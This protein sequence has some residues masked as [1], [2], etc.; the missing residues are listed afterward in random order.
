MHKTQQESYLWLHYFLILMQTLKNIFAPSS[1]LGHTW[2]R[3]FHK[4]PNLHKPNKNTHCLLKYETKLID[5]E[6]NDKIDLWHMDLN[7]ALILCVVS[8]CCISFTI[9]FWALSGHFT[10]V[11][12]N[13]EATTKKCHGSANATYNIFFCWI[14]YPKFSLYQQKQPIPDPSPE[15]AP[16]PQG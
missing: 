2:C 8:S 4:T 10:E 14:N 7:T 12:R 6:N 15:S 1:I 3:N 11:N 9:N 13:T 5:F 16:R